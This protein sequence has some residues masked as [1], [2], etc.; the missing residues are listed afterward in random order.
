MRSNGLREPLTFLNSVHITNGNRNMEQRV[1]S[2]VNG[3][4]KCCKQIFGLK[5]V[6]LCLHCLDVLAINGVKKNSL[7]HEAANNTQRNFPI[8]L[9]E[10]MFVGHLV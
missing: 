10:K 5:M 8:R 4:I 3:F 9:L 2:V 1:V 6:K 7:G